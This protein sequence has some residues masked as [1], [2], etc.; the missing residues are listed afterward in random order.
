MCYIDLQ[1]W[2]SDSE[3]YKEDQEDNQEVVGKENWKTV[4]LPSRNNL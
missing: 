3:L 1:N 4:Q 2:T